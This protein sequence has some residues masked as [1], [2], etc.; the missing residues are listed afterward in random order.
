LQR[1][2]F[3]AGFAAFASSALPAAR[4][5]P[6]R[7]A[8]IGIFHFGSAANF[9]KRED[10]F[11]REMR[12]LGYD[13]KR[14]QFYVEGAYGQPDLLESTARTFAREPLDVILSASSLTT[15][16]LRRA[17]PETPI[18]IAA[19]ED[20]VAEKFADSLQRPG[21]NITGITASVLDHLRRQLD[22]LERVQPRLTRVIALLNPDNPTH[23]KYRARL[24]ALARAGTRI[25]VADARNAGEIE[26][27]FPSRP[28]DD[29]EGVLVMNDGLFYTE[30]RS[31]AEAAARA[32]RATVYPLR[33]Y[34]EAGGLMSYGPNLEANFAR[35]AHFVHR[36][37]TG[38]RASDI[39]IEPPTRIEL[40]LNRDAAHA[41]KAV[42]PSDLLKEAAAVLG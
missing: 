30:R 23:A 19:A 41:I 3:L 20:P 38:E 42:L 21:R 4:A 40:V 17:A 37:L 9:R 2:L 12:A 33:G 11:R 14:A 15:D 18:V 36:I 28:R 24:D 31:I 35:A 10:A 34:V 32:R 7:A 39:P 26:R 29:A 25:V 27:A 22:L 1:R 8:R 5:Q 6:A 16:A 13:E